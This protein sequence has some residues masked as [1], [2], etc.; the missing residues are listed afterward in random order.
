[1]IFDDLSDFNND[2]STQLKNLYKKILKNEKL[3]KF[4]KYFKNDLL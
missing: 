2:I 1:M 4:V 3:I